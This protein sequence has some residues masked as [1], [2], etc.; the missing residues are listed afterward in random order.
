MFDRWGGVLYG[1]TDPWAEW[2]GTAGGSPVPGG[3]YPFRAYAIDA[4]KGDRYELF[5]HVT[6]VR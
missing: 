2:D 6:I 4:I 3:V 5:G 1:T